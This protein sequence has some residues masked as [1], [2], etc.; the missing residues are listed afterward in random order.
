MES[1]ETEE[2]DL[3]AEGGAKKSHKFPIASYPA[4]TGKMCLLVKTR[5]WVSAIRLNWRG[6]RSPSSPARGE[7]L[8]RGW[9]G[10]PRKLL[11][12]NTFN[13]IIFP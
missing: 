10:G 13:F 3:V 7:N 6:P 4:V 8:G 1:S 12:A 2:E 5:N 11:F 9:V